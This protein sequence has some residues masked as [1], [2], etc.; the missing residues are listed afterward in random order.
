MSVAL[1]V[2]ERELAILAGC[3]ETHA[4]ARKHRSARQIVQLEAVLM[5]QLLALFMLCGL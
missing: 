4:L 1:P 5:R 2:A 3:C